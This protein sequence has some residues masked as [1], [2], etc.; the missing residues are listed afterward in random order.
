MLADLSEYTSS[1]QSVQ[2]KPKHKPNKTAKQQQKNKTKQNKTNK[3]KKQCPWVGKGQGADDVFRGF[4]PRSGSG[5]FQ[6]INH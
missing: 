5:L 4:F 6:V 2:S 3:Q 1:I